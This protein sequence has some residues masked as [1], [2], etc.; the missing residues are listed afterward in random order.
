R[1]ALTTAI[2]FVEA[3]LKDDPAKVLETL[4]IQY[5]ESPERKQLAIQLHHRLLGLLYAVLTAADIPEVQ[6]LGKLTLQTPLLQHLNACGQHWDSAWIHPLLDNYTPQANGVAENGRVDAFLQHACQQLHLNQQ[7]W[8]HHPTTW[9]TVR[10][11][12][13]F[14]L[15]TPA[16]S[17]A[18]GSQLLPVL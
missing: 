10:R 2:G 8:T 1:K 13:M 11:L 4:S 6:Q 3:A 18:A 14:L 5:P 17:A 9:L 15:E 16:A 7:L 12:L